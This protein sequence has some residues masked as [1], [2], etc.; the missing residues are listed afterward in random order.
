MDFKNIILY[1]PPGTGKTYLSS[2]LAV[3]IIEKGK[4]ASYQPQDRPQRKELFRQYQQEGR[5]AFVTFHQSF[6]YEDFV[7]GIKP[8]KN[9][10]NELYYD[11]ED[12]V[13]K[14][15]CY[16]ATYA[17]WLTQQRRWMAKVAHPGRKN[18]DILYFEFLD[19]LKR[20]MKEGSKEVVFETL[21]QKTVYLENINKNDT[22]SFRYDQGRRTYGITKN[23][24]ARAY[25]HFQQSPATPQLSDEF[26]KDA[27]NANTSLYWAVCSRLQEFERARNTTYN[28]IINQRQFQGQPVSE[29]QYQQ[30][31]RD[32]RH[33]DFSQLS[34]EDYQQAGNYVLIIDEINR[35]N[36]AG[37]FGELI[38][39]LEDD[40]RAGRPEALQTILPYSRERFSIPPNLYI[41]GTMN[42]A[43]RS[44]EAL[45]TALRRR[46]SFRE[47]RPAPDLL[48]KP[49]PHLAMAAEGGA[50]YKGRSKNRPSPGIALDALLEVMNQRLEK[51]IDRDH[52]L[53]HGY[54]MPV[55]QA[56]DPLAALKEIFYQQIIPLLQEYF[57]SDFVKM[58]MVIGQAFFKKEETDPATTAS[59]FFAE[60]G[61]DTALQEEY[62]MKPVRKIMYLDDEAF[63]EA[64]LR[65]YE[66]HIP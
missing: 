47:L 54:F 52:T 45:D 32:L 31:K 20:M 15:I 33:F 17:L 16:N 26:R 59:S 53:G 44:I 23:K 7:E 60:S 14:Q 8:F 62:F 50:T 38:T 46:F 39:L 21:T 3:A 34:E 27:G 56:S 29:E 36:I 37:I 40:K 22:L 2:D 19:Y 49:S 35:G 66:R 43:D 65:I 11:V 24:L 51:L 12:G 63:K 18:F 5:I 30:M 28:Y 42:T 13:F 55:G 61:M 48:Q 1:G 10:K 41:I 4:A 25:R 64:I 58:E 9:E 6:S 57:F